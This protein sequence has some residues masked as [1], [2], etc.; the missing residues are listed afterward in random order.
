M[1]LFSLIQIVSYSQYIR[2]L[3]LTF[4]EF[5]NRAQDAAM[6][7]MDAQQRAEEARL[8]VQGI[9]DQLPEDRRKIEQIPLDVVNTNRLVARA[10]SQGIKNNFPSEKLEKKIA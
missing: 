3:N 8:R 4:L 9:L 6:K 5:G 2:F 10:R 1:I 7:A